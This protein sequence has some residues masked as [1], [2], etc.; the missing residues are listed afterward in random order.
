M[1]MVVSKDIKQ[2]TREQYAFFESL[3]KNR[4]KLA[5]ALENPALEGFEDIL[6]DI[7]S[8]KTHF[9]YELLQNADDAKATKVRFVLDSNGLLFIHNG[10]IHFSISDPEKEREDKK[11]GKLGHV[12]SITSIASSAK[13]GTKKI[14]PKIG[15]FGIGFKSV[16]QY[17][18]IPYIYD[19]P[20]ML[21]I[22]R[23]IVPELLQSDHPAR[24]GIETLFNFPFDSEKQLPEKAYEEIKERLK[25]LDNPLL[26]LRH[27]EE[28]EWR[29]NEGEVGTYLKPVSS[30]NSDRI[31]SLVTKINGKSDEQKFLI[32]DKKIDSFCW[33]E[34]P[35]NDYGILTEFLKQNFSIDWIKAAKIEKFDGLSTIRVYTDRNSLLLRLNIDKTKV[36]LEIDGRRTAEFIAKIENGKLIIYFDSN[37]FNHTISV[38]FK[39]DLKEN[40]IIPG[41]FYPYC[42][43]ATGGS[44]K[45][46]FIVQAPFLLTSNRTG[47]KEKDD[48][49]NDLIKHLAIFIA[50]TLPKI[51]EMELLNIDFLKVLP[52]SETEF[53]IYRMFRPIYDAVLNKL[54]NDEKFLPANGGG[55]INAKQACLADQYDLID[56]LDK[57]QLSFLFEKPDA[58]WLDSNITKENTSELWLYLSK[59]L[60]I[61]IIT[62]EKFCSRFT[63]NFIKIQNDEWVVKL[64]KFLKGKKYLWGKALRNKPYIRL[65]HDIHVAP[66]DYN[67]KPKVYLP[68]NLSSSSRTV[69]KTLVM[70][71][72][73]RE[74][75]RGEMNLPI[76]DKIDEIVE[77][78]LSKYKKKDEINVSDEKNLEDL[79]KIIEA[80]KTA[81]PLRK[82]DFFKELNQCSFLL[83]LNATTQ[84]KSWHKP[85]EVYL[86]KYYDENNN[87]YLETYFNGNP[88]VCFIDNIIYKDFKKQDLL[89]LGCSDKPRII[90]EEFR[91]NRYR[92]G[93]THDYMMDG[94]EFCIK[95]N[96]LEKNIQVS[97]YIWGLLILSQIDK[98]Y[99]I[100]FKGTLE[101]AG[102]QNYTGSY[103]RKVEK[104]SKVYEILTDHKWL[105]TKDGDFCKPS[106]ILLSQLPDGFENQ[107]KEA[108]DIARELNF[109]TDA[110]QLFKEHVNPELKKSYESFVRAHQLIPDLDDMLDE[111]IEKRMDNPMDNSL[112][113]KIIDDS[114][115]TPPKPL[116]QGAHQTG[117]VFTPEEE[118]QIHNN[119]D[120]ELTERLKNVKLTT[121]GKIT[122]GSKI[123]D[124]IDPKEF[125]LCQY[126]GYCQI[127]NT[128]LDIGSN[129]KY[130]K[131]FRI[132]ETRRRYAFTNMEW[133][134]LCLCPNCHALMKHGGRDLTN[135]VDTA[136]K[137]SKYEIA[138]DE[139]PNRGLLYTIIIKVAGKD[140]DIFYSQEHMNKLAAFVQQTMGKD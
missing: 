99:E 126:Q 21:K 117:V 127:C 9:I 3:I 48:W 115:V 29:T 58:Q 77:I 14:E 109:L 56:L 136:R 70:D 45:L 123:V 110:E 42:F 140:V 75:L 12:N 27:I 98:F 35:I 119:Y 107:T 82:G 46:R 62:P 132:V 6:T 31:V 97:K 121:D 81:P 108:M 120:K 24:E 134:V 67:D 37:Q 73:V 52:I 51:K 1:K 19:P 60:V 85:N 41:D 91:I 135:I 13:G 88:N 138:P 80:I 87:D 69:K 130:F 50:N 133:N 61:D 7:Y 15:K 100:K 2:M 8:E 28:I 32:F 49:N 39:L 11:N 116:A 55:Y 33:D 5:E 84:E 71:E 74:F 89:E 78:I 36:S 96:L 128:V 113:P 38:A 76:Y 53:P 90:T 131:T 16:F 18:N 93:F 20:F 111:L 34:I 92:R 139:V 26:F 64:Y 124:I 25:G 137:V 125:L 129:K 104:K 59:N 63:E 94:L 30:L 122:I 4:E 10:K 68:N 40:K 66:F 47:I 43:F 83:A 101:H 57:G 95:N 102:D 86:P 112:T 106:D 79:T 105:P 65:E 22:K 114:M 118:E 54:K 17:T 72:E 23:F 103:V 44:T